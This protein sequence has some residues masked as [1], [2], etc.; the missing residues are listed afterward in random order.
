M[1]TDEK[2]VGFP[3]TVSVDL[4]TFPYQQVAGF[5][6]NFV[7]KKYGTEFTYPGRSQCNFKERNRKGLYR[8]I[9]G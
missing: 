7:N 8:R 2:T 9:H 5:L 3:G 6:N 1:A 4:I